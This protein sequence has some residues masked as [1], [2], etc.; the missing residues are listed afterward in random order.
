MHWAVRTVKTQKAAAK[1]GYKPRW[2][3]SKAACLY[4][5][6]FVYTKSGFP[7]EMSATD[8]QFSQRD[9]QCL[10]NHS[11]ISTHTGWGKSKFAVVCMG[12]NIISNMRVNCF[13]YNCKPTLSH[14]VFTET[15]L[16]TCYGVHTVNSH[17]PCC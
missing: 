16:C 12:S 14:P 6:L 17:C 10:L 1:L 13:T 3:R 4:N 11:L 5:L 8:T 15:L 2:G 7:G 9:M